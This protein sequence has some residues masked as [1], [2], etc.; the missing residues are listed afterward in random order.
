LWEFSERI[1][2]NALKT[3]AFRNRR[4]SEKHKRNKQYLRI[5]RIR[6]LGLDCM[7]LEFVQE[8]AWAKKEQKTSW[9][10]QI[11]TK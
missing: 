11:R 10:R 1:V 2:K 8:C 3:T 4:N 9:K 7:E 5:K 6:E